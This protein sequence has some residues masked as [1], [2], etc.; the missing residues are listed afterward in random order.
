MSQLWQAKNIILERHLHPDTAL[1]L[2]LLVYLAIISL[3]RCDYDKDFTMDKIILCGT[4]DSKQQ[5]QYPLV[6]K[7]DVVH[8]RQQE[9]TMARET[10]RR[11][12]WQRQ[13]GSSENSP[14]KPLD[15]HGCGE[16]SPADTLTCIQWCCTQTSSFPN[17][18]K[19]HLHTYIFSCPLG[20]K[21]LNTATENKHIKSQQS[22]L[23]ATLAPSGDSA[24]LI[25]D[26]LYPPRYRSWHQQ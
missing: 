21:F 12:L 26:S 4:G 14:V 6:G 19:T 15:E 13:A 17:G 22:N 10:A 7:G 3:C 24:N 25:S 2:W 16:H 23:G 20:C 18:E 1:K 9:G 11:M 8:S 5:F